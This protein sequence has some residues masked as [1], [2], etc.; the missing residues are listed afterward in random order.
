M[1]WSAPSPEYGYTAGR[2]RQFASCDVNRRVTYQSTNGTVDQRQASRL[3][4]YA[5]T[6]FVF[7]GADFPTLPNIGWAP[8]IQ[9]INTFL[10]CMD[11]CAQYNVQSSTWECAGVS[12][13][14]SGFLLK[15]GGNLATLSGCRSWY[16][17]NKLIPGF[18]L[19]YLIVIEVR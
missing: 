13:L 14:D 12:W 1:L 6:F 5:L 4:G 18:R 9:N 3:N 2:S 16:V 19:R 10:D 8:T 11:Y 7:C 17:R 15:K